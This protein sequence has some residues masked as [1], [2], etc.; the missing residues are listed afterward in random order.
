MSQPGE[1]VVRTPRRRSFKHLSCRYVIDRVGIWRYQRRFPDHPWLTADAIRALTA[2]L[3]PCDEGLEWGSG[4]STV[5]FA[6]RVHRLT[7][8]EH[9]PQWHSRVS[10]RLQAQALTNV[11]YH[12]C[13]L[14]DETDPGLNEKYTGVADRFGPESLDFVL[15][16][17]QL[18]SACALRALPKLRPGGLFIVD[19]INWYLPCPSRAPASIAVDGEP[20]NAEWKQFLGYVANWRC[21]WSSNGVTDTACWIK[22]A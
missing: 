10:Q 12:L 8:V 7:S 14:G 2:M 9:N 11:D 15:V 5:W 20:A 4:R 13:E 1:S 17:G 21:L 16:D 3:R 22:C 6:H 19:N 18:R